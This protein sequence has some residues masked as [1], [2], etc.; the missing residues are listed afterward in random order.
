MQF[1]IHYTFGTRKCFLSV[2]LSLL[3]L[4][5]SKLKAVFLMSFIN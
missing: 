2:G 3:G 5:D 1:R 4:D